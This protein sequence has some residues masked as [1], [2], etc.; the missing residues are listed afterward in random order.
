MVLTCLGIVYIYLH[1]QNYLVFK[2]LGVVYIYTDTS[3]EKDRT[4]LLLYVCIVFSLT[5]KLVILGL[6]LMGLGS[7]KQESKTYGFCLL[8]MLVIN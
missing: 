2:C 8:N 7:C 1:K 5:K 3:K 4:W 6:M